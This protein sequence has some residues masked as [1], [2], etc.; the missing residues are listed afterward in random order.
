MNGGWTILHENY[1][2]TACPATLALLHFKNKSNDRS[3][4]W[5]FSDS[6]VWS[7]TSI[8]VSMVHNWPES[9][10]FRKLNFEGVLQSKETIGRFSKKELFRRILRASFQVPSRR[11]NAGILSVWVYSV[12]RLA[13]L[14]L[15]AGNSRN[16]LNAPEEIRWSKSSGSHVLSQRNTSVEEG[17]M[18]FISRA[19]FEGRWNSRLL[20]KIQNCVVVC[21]LSHNAQMQLIN[22]KPHFVQLS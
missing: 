1:G 16:T 13:R 20:D 4:T 9:A 10:P 5:A 18:S 8:A 11:M 21:V 19:V 17:L 2:F 14:S 15:S 6:P 7:S 22:G 12:W 3:K